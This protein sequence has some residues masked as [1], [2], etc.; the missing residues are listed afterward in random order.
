MPQFAYL[1]DDGIFFATAKSVA[2]G[3][4]YRLPTLPEN[5]PQ[6][7]FPPLFPL[8]LSLIWRLAANFPEN[9][10]LATLLCWLTLPVLLVLAWRLYQSYGFPRSRIILIVFL[11]GANPFLILFGC[12]MFSEVF[13]TCL[14][15][16]SFLLLRR[17]GMRAAIIAG[18]V[19]GLA[20]LSRTAGIAML[21]SVPAV[22]LLRREGKRAAAFVAG[23]LPAVIAWTVWTRTHLPNTTDSTLIYY[24]DYV[25]YQFLNVGLDNLGVVLWKNL[26]EIFHALGSLVFP[27][28]IQLYPLRILL[29]VIAAAAIGGVVRLCRQKILVD[30]A[31][32]ALVSLA[33]L[34]VWHFPTTERFVLPVYPLLLAGLVTEIEH[35]WKMIRAGFRHK[36]RSQR[37]AARIFSAGVASVF[38]IALVVQLFLTFDYLKQNAD[39]Q[40][41][42]LQD[43]R[44]AYTWISKNLPANA[45]ILSYD[46]GL[47]YLYTSHRGNYLPLLPRWW[48]AE[49]HASAVEAYRNLPA[50]CRAR[51]LDYVYFTTE[52]LSRETDDD[53]R[54]Q[55]QQ[56]VRDNPQ[57]KAVFTAGI[58]TVYRV[59][60]PV[61]K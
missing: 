15:I 29:Y 9:L 30:Y 6:T 19:A 35:I 40:G 57:L 24:T 53:T 2:A 59:E 32:F 13:F 17:M 33:I 58:G 25:R 48:Y 10:A 22:L 27:E 56:V 26:F 61:P 45:N 28:L 46:D 42:K 5:P 54:H 52:D 37:I 7:K 23:M 14:V 41:V 51:G 43:L 8:Y 3:D 36:D 34:E 49:D 38:G 47:M 44:T 1:H 50:Y 21:V 18:L 60:P 12:M 39:Q 20:Y 4:G 55:V 11:L 31:A 16:A